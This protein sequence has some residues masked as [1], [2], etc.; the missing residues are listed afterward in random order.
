[1]RDRQGLRQ[2]PSGEVGIGRGGAASGNRKTKIGLSDLL[3][4][5]RAA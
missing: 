1:V 4:P 5:G 3:K 2:Q